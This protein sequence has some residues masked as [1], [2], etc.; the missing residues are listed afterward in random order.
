V[1][2]AP[3]TRMRLP[4]LA[5]VKKIEDPVVRVSIRQSDEYCVRL[6]RHAYVVCV[7]VIR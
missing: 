6:F 1:T 2:L 7:F 4:D 3:I 5:G